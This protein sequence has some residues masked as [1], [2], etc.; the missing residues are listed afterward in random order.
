MLDNSRYDTTRAEEDFFRA[1][2]AAGAAFRGK[3]DNTR[4]QVAESLGVSDENVT[5]KPA[6]TEGEKD[7]ETSPAA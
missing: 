3:R 7:A 1:L 6:K 4:T 5:L 2:A